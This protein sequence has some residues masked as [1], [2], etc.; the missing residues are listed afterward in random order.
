VVAQKTNFHF[1]TPNTEFVTSVLRWC[2]LA[3]TYDRFG[4]PC[5][6]RLQGLIFT[7]EGQR[8]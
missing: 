7:A 8:K 6:L 2:K 5:C 4:E 1:E 3:R